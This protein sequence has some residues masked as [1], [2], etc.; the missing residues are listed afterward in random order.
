MIDWLIIWRRGVIAA[1]RR[2]ACRLSAAV[3]WVC[4]HKSGAPWPRRRAGAVGS[5]G[6]RRWRPRRTARMG[7]PRRW[8]AWTRAAPRSCR[9][10]EA[11]GRTG[12]APTRRRETRACA[13][14]RGGGGGA[15][16]GEDAA[17]ARRSQPKR[18]KISGPMDHVPCIRSGSDGK[19]EGAGHQESVRVAGRRTTTTNSLFY[20]SRDIF[21]YQVII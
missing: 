3:D 20:N 8:R 7:R 5:R 13:C 9:S 21:N 15:P 6:G 18:R 19:K 17:D 16:A 11:S 4:L 12:G 1:W 2:A 10:I 14:G